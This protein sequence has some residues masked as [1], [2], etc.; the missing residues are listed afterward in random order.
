MRV[1]PAEKDP[2]SRRARCIGYIINLAAREFIYGKDVEAFEFD[3]AGE[4][5]N[6]RSESL[7]AKLA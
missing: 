5:I 2:D 7:K 6:A 1:D 3:I 4:D